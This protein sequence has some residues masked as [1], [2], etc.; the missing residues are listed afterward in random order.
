MKYKVGDKVRIKGNSEPYKELN[1]ERWAKEIVELAKVGK[2]AVDKKTKKPVRC[3]YFPCEQ[4]LFCDDC[5]GLRTEWFDS[6]YVA[7]KPKIQLTKFEH[8]YLK[9]V[10]E[11]GLKYIARDK[12]G[13]TYVFKG[14][15]YKFCNV[16]D[17]SGFDCERIIF[18]YLFEFVTWEDEEPYNISEILNNCEVIE[19]VD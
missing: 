1:K 14:K 8:E 2:I 6:E 12:T 19:N 9:R 3:I 13:G 15:P 17:I 7:P 11:L 16:W 5:I 4:C 18:N 10:L